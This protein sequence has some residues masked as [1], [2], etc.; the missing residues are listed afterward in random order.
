[1][2]VRNFGR[3]DAW[4]P[5]R[6]VHNSGPLSYKVQTTEG[7]I[8]RRHRDHVRGTCVDNETAKEAEDLEVTDK[9]LSTSTSTKTVLKPPESPDSTPV[10]DNPVVNFETPD[11]PSLRRSGRTIK[12]PDKLNL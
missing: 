6:I 1:M 2:W 7:V 8:T 4:I 10:N 9:D 5:G 3:G 12:P 11:Q